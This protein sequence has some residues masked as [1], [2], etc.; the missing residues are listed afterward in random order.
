MKV[1]P[2]LILLL[3]FLAVFFP[4]LKLTETKVKM[5]GENRILLKNFKTDV[6]PKAASSYHVVEKINMKFGGYNT[7]YVS[8][9]SQVKTNICPIIREL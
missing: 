9:L 5:E 3:F 7:T 2:I 4:K 8:D 6:K 1:L